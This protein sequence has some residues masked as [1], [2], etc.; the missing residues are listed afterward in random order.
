MITH[1]LEGE[2]V[3]LEEV[4]NEVWTVYFGPFCLGRFREGEW[5]LHGTYAYNTPA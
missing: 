1:V 5:K 3:G 2:Y 4:D